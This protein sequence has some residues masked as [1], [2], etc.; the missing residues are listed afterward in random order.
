VKP[1]RFA[2]IISALRAGTTYLRPEIL[3]M[4]SSAA[5]TTNHISRAQ[6][7]S[8]R[9][10]ERGVTI[11]IVAAGMVSLLAMAVLAIDV[12]TLY[13]ASGQAQQAAD[14]AALAGAAAFSSSGFTS[15]PG[16]VA[17][18]SVCN[19]SSGDADMRAQAVA[20]TFK[21]GG[22]APSSIVTSC[23]FT[24]VE[25]PQLTVTVTR[26]GLPS[27]FARIWGY[28]GSTVTATAKAE[29]Y[30][31]SFN[32]GSS[33]SPTIDVTGVKP[34]LVFNCQLP[35]AAPNFIT[36]PNYAISNP[37]LIGTRITFPLIT[38]NIDPRTVSS[39][40]IPF[41]AID[42][43]APVSCPSAS[44][45]SCNQIGTG[46]PGLFYHD[47]IACRGTGHIACGQ[48]IGPGQPIQVDTRSLGNLQARTNAG[49]ECLIHANGSD[50]TQGQDTFTAGPP[51]VIIGGGSNNPNS[52]MRLASSISRSDSVVTVPVFNCPAGTCDATVNLQIAGFLQLGI[53]GVGP[54][55]SIIPP[56]LPGEISA[57]VLNI[58][59]CDPSNPGNPIS[60]AGISPVP[61]R[62]TR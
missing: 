58:A 2:A 59:G 44:A 42:P 16:I 40:K 30:N 49:T 28:S 33:P 61:V 56:V 46:P 39:P 48:I 4:T 8:S 18:S 12:V 19:G 45:V 26:T 60:G 41:Y 15:A 24:E 51:P 43:P 47:N 11:F 34:W 21:I 29:A 22:T 37:A 62:L 5:K 53:Q 20:G 9:K 31:P 52:S 35:C 6:Q 55:P 32:L 1:T 23:N 25:N 50:L 17:Q 54:I 27:F 57:V 13:V 36:Y 3:A 14:A 38:S 7:K 10:G